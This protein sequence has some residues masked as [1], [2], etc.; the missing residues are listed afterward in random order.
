MQSVRSLRENLAAVFGREWLRLSE[1]DQSLLVRDCLEE[2]GVD[3]LGQYRRAIGT[4]N[5]FAYVATQRVRF[6]AKAVR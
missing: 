1:A 2:G 3:D 4:G 6:G 5:L